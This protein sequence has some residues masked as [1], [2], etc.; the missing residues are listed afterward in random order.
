MFSPHV[1]YY[2]KVS[3]RILTPHV[4]NMNTPRGTIPGA[5]GISSLLAL[6]CRINDTDSLQAV[7]TQD[8]AIKTK[9]YHQVSGLLVH[10]VSRVTAQ[11]VDLVASNPPKSADPSRA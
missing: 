3:A 2:D 6:K 9:M 11:L 5:R 4:G 1:H 7:L 8:R 10:Q